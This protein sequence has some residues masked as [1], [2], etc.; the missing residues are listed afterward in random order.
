M[1]NLL[2]SVG[3]VLQFYVTFLLVVEQD[4]RTVQFE[5]TLVK[6][7]KTMYNIFM[8]VLCMNELMLLCGCYSLDSWLNSVPICHYCGIHLAVSDSVYF[9]LINVDIESHG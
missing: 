7:F 6:H 2:P 3:T 4:D 5:L 1:L 8:S 9:C